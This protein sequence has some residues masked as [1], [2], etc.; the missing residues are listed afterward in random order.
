MPDIMKMGKNPNY[1]GSWDLDEQPNRE[2]TFR[3][4]RLLFHIRKDL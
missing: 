1:L 3:S 2:V 4:G